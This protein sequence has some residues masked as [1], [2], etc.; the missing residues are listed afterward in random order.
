MVEIKQ[1]RL[2]YFYNVTASVLLVIITY[3][4]YECTTELKTKGSRRPKTGLE[5]E[6]TEEGDK[7]LR[8]LQNG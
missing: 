5:E 4:F 7:M 6:I 3:Y 2:H 1:L 8:L